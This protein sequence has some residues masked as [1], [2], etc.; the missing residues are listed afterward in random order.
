MDYRQNEDFENSA[1]DKKRIAIIST[2][3]AA[4][5]IVIIAGILISNKKSAKAA[6]FPGGFGM[7]GGQRGAVAVRTKIVQPEDMQ[8]YVSTNG[9]VETQVSLDVFPSIGGTVVQMNVALGSSVKKGDVIGYVDPSEPGS[10]FAKSPLIAPMTG[11]ILT[12][13][14]K[15]GQKI[16][17]TTVVT[18]V[19]DISNLQITAKVPERYVSDLKIGQKAD[20]LLQAYPDMVFAA[21]VVKISPVVD[22]A[23]RTKDVIL[24]FEKNYP[25][26]NA[27]M[28]AKVK[29]YTNVYSSHIVLN[30]DSI[31]ENS[32]KHYLYVVNADDETVS[33]K[34]V[35]LG[36]NVDGKY[37][38]LSGV[39]PGDKVVIEG[40][41]TL[42]EGAQIND[43]DKKKE[44]KEA[45]E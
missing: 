19:G 40:M 33:R 11:S 43:V 27:G 23:T 10:Y 30:Q 20:V 31:I 41:L 39:E 6:A 35:T 3:V 4:I 15:V 37:Q 34:E 7:A 28:F 45:A 44:V 2:I 29:L 18:R 14:V 5:L 25:Q 22:S 12:S 24:N 9:D 8:D 13:P 38:I 1:S 32:D 26:V 42:F 17:P 36:K 16:G 21:K